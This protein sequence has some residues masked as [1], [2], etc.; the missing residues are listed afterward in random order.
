MAGKIKATPQT[1][2]TTA[3]KFGKEATNLQKSIQTM[4]GLI[5]SLDNYWEGDATIAY[6]NRYA[7]LKKS[8]N[9]AVELMNELKNNLNASANILEET[10][11]KIAGK[12]K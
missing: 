4:N 8:F 6:K 2:R 11:Q 12:I 3:G 7:V 1:M 5:D 10:D 9:N